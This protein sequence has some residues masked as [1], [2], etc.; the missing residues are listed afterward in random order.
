MPAPDVARPRPFWSDVRFLIGIALVVVSVAGVWLVVS[1]ARQ[2]VPVFAAARTIAGGER[3][4][5]DDLRVVEV[6]LGPVAGAYATPRTWQP[7]AVATRTIAAGELVPADAIG[8]EAD[9]DT[10]TVVVET[11]GAVPAEVA[12]GAAVEVWAAPR[13]DAGTFGEP[14]ILLRTATVL[15]VR[16]DD[17]LLARAAASLE[18]IVDR[19]DVGPALAAVAAGDAISV[20]PAVGR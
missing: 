1:A 11:T 6:A 17:A 13:Q 7:G 18:L 15:A 19:D 2:T 8:D 5:S 14:R 16:E 4:D 10:T 9:L 3:V 12:G 20:V